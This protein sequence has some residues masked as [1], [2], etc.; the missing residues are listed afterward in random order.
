MSDWVLVRQSGREIEAWPESNLV[1][2]LQPYIMRA[3]GLGNID[4]PV[5][6]THIRVNRKLQGCSFLS[7]VLYVQGVHL[8]LVGVSA[9]VT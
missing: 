3:N 5:Q 1:F 9:V 8:E 6:S 4:I 2:R 7:Q